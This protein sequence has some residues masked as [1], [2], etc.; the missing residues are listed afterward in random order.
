M[1]VIKTCEGCGAKC[2][3]YVA[4]EIDCPE[5]LDDFENIKWY[6]AHENIRVFVE[7]DNVWNIEFMTSCK[8]LDGEKC[9]I[10]EE[11]VKNP[12]AKRPKICGEFTADACPNHNKYSEKYEFNSIEDVDLYLVDVFGKGKHVVSSE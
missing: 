3:K 10:H 9:S 8:Y 11:F 6:V 12:K 5:D 1:E 7:V 2:C 4:M